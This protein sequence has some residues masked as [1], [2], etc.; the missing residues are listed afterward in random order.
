[1][2]GNKEY[3]QNF[4]G[5]STWKTGRRQEGNIKEVSCEDGRWMELAWDH[6]Q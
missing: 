2:G 3:I 4:A 1:M 5:K 6:V